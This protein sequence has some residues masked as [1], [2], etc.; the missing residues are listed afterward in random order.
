MQFMNIK[1]AKGN[2]M[3]TTFRSIENR[4][5]EVVAFSILMDAERKVGLN[6]Q[7]L[8]AECPDRRFERALNLL[9]A[10]H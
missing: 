6:S 4:Y 7:A 2:K 1:H 9:A 8:A 10:R 3:P 5:G